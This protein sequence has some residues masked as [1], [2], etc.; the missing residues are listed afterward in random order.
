MLIAHSTSACVKRS[1]E[2]FSTVM[3]ICTHLQAIFRRRML[4]INISRRLKF[5]FFLNVR[6]IFMF[7]ENTVCGWRWSFGKSTFRWK[8]NKFSWTFISTDSGRLLAGVFV[9]L[10]SII[11]GII[12]SKRQ[13]TYWCYSACDDRWCAKL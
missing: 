10:A 2:S 13:S 1:H 7:S 8:S 4:T 6:I 11:L 9:P 5:I 12:A 3:L